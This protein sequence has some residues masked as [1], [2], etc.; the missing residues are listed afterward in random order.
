DSATPSVLA[1]AAAVT[2]IRASRDACPSVSSAA[3]SMCSREM[4]RV[5]VGAFGLM[6][7]KA[8]MSSSLWT[9]SAGISPSAIPQK[10]HSDGMGTSGLVG[11]HRQVA[12]DLPLRPVECDDRADRSVR[13]LTVDG[14]DHHTRDGVL[15]I[16][17]GRS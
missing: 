12:A 8:T 9:M 7:R 15:E 16:A 2:N 6:S 11:Q 3:D 4:S 14:L 13:D 1:R 17:P 10:R 5:W